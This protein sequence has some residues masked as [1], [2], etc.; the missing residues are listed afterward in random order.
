MLFYALSLTYLKQVFEY[1]CDESWKGFHEMMKNA[2]YFI[3]KTFFVLKVF[4]LLS[5]L[6]GYVEK[7]AWL[8][9]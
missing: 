9:R 3:R 4:K 1:F 5:W 7:T 6:F 2:L 8:E